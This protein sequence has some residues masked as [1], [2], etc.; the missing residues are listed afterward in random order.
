MTYYPLTF[1]SKINDKG[2]E[3]NYIGIGT[4]YFLPYAFE[5][6]HLT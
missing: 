3:W 6:W 2:K 1:C 4:S 5:Q